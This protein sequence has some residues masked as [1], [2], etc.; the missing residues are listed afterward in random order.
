MKISI[1]LIM[2]KHIV[3]LMGSAILLITLALPSCRNSGSDHPR[4]PIAETDSIY[5]SDSLTV[6]DCFA[7]VEI[8]GQYPHA[9]Q[10]PLLDSVRSW[11][12][13]RLNSNVMDI[14]KP[15][16]PITPQMLASGKDLATN[17]GKA[18]LK[19]A[20][21]DFKGFAH[22]SIAIEYEFIYNFNPV[23]QTDSVVTYAFTGYGYMGGA[24]GYTL[25]EGQTFIASTGERLTFANTFRQEASDSIVA[26][27]R[28]ALRAQY[29]NE[30]D[31]AEVPLR[32]LLLVNPDS[33]PLPQTPPQFQKDGVAFI[34]QQ[35]E[36]APYA[37]GIPKCVLPYEELKPMM[38]PAAARLVP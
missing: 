2:K 22:D 36:I 19:T 27:I 30:T 18:L 24:H 33:L 5:W 10:K 32:D 29:F 28:E 15:L 38:K 25:D 3:S 23:F 13:A 6:A 14:G 35:Y 26:R 37:A 21:N 31:S 9:G 20:D 11:L 17:T 12:G 1:D 7:S 16:F 34:Y 8:E 4:M